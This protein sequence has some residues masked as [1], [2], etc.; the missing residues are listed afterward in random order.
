MLISFFFLLKL[1]QSLLLEFL[2]TESC[3]FHS[4][5]SCLSCQT[6]KDVTFTL[7]DIQK[8]FESYLINEMF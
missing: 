3:Q 6:M 5:F 8:K 7:K 1:S 4:I 2:L